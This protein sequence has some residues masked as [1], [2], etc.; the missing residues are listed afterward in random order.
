[1]NQIYADEN[2]ALIKESIAKVEAAGGYMGVSLGTTKPEEQKFW[3]Q[4]GCRLVS[5]SL[6]CTNHLD[7]HSYTDGM[8]Y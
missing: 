3:M 4:L 7:I 5:A 8:P 1:M 6:F 2:I